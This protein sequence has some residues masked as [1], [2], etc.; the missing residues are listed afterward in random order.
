MFIFFTNT[1]TFIF[2]M[3]IGIIFIP[4]TLSQENRASTEEKRTQDLIQLEKISKDGQYGLEVGLSYEFELKNEHLGAYLEQFEIPSIQKNLEIFLWTPFIP[5]ENGPSQ[6]FYQLVQKEIIERYPNR[7]NMRLLQKQHPDA[8][9][10]LTKNL[11]AS[12]VQSWLI[13]SSASNITQPISP[14]TSEK[15]LHTINILGKDGKPIER[16]TQIQ[17]PTTHLESSKSSTLDPSNMIKTNSGLFVPA[18]SI[19]IPEGEKTKISTTDIGDEI[20]KRWID[21]PPVV[22]N[23]LI[24]FNQLNRRYKGWIAR[25][26]LNEPPDLS[27]LK[28]TAPKWM[29]ETNKSHWEIG[30]SLEIEHKG[31]FEDRSSYRKRLNAI[32]QTLGLS[33][34]ID[35]PLDQIDPSYSFHLNISVKDYP[36]NKLST[37]LTYYQDIMLGRFLNSEKKQVAA[38]ADGYGSY[39]NNLES[40]GFIR[41]VNAREGY[42][43]LRVHTKG[44]E[45]TLDE[46]FKYLADMK[47]DEQ[48]TIKRMKNDLRKLI[49]PKFME[50][51]LTS[52]GLQEKINKLNPNN[53]NYQR[54]FDAIMLENRQVMN[55]KYNAL[56]A[57]LFRITGTSIKGLHG[58]NYFIDLG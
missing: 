5:N 25:E 6:E 16:N 44:P 48:A 12:A 2:V 4:T 24:D 39:Q 27:M 52:P 42:F 18:Q 36:P 55:K 34:I 51:M 17:L 31:Y 50:E 41:I 29:K 45:E 49:T 38:F 8:F 26:V 35:R 19:L 57:M 9:A 13:I 10:E 3:M 23:K 14:D 37:F 11:N 28:S 15:N 20:Y 30:A 22:R 21:L 56:D 33:Y 7:E 32:T 1:I 47:N 43:E 53:N 46:V 54:Q 40:K 58:N